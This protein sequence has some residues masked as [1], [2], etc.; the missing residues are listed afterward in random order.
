M[1]MLRPKSVSQHPACLH[2][3]AVAQPRMQATV[4][5][6]ACICRAFASTR[7]HLDTCTFGHPHNNMCIS[8]TFD[9]VACLRAQQGA[10][11]NA[12]VFHLCVHRHK[13]AVMSV[14]SYV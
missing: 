13:H 6:D 8:L 2:A 11:I 7:L 3:H 9:S 4:Q 5:I 10:H 1:G 14:T 12:H